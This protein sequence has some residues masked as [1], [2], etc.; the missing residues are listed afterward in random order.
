MDKTLIRV[1]AITSNNEIQQMNM[2]DIMVLLY[3]Y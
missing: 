1:E 3:G 2:N